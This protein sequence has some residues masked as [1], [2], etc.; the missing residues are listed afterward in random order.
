MR[1]VTWKY[2]KIDSNLNIKNKS[3]VD[4]LTKKYKVINVSDKQ[5]KKDIKEVFVP[6]FNSFDSKD[7][8]S[9]VRDKIFE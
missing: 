1:H 7:I 5:S 2:N 9:S 3:G 4:P 6:N 8:D